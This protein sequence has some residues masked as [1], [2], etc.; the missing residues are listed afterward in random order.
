M[1]STVT[2]LRFPGRYVSVL[3]NASHAEAV[4]ACKSDAAALFG[5]IRVNPAN[6]ATADRIPTGNTPLLF[7]GS[8]GWLPS[9]SGL[10]IPDPGFVQGKPVGLWWRAEVDARGFMKPLVHVFLDGGIRAMHPRMGGP[11][12]FDLEGQKRQAGNTGVGTYAVENGQFVQRYDG[13]ENK[14]AHSSGSDS[15]GTYFKSGAE[16]FR[17]LTLAT[18]Q[19]ID[20]HWRGG[21]SE[22]NF[23]AD[24]TYFY[25]SSLAKKGSSG[26]YRLDG[27][28]IQMIPNDGRGAIDMIG[29]GGETLVMGS[30][31]LFRVK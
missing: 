26:R 27:Y 29:M 2:V 1:I 16:V 5:S 25:G 8:V 21:Q 19:S 13:F 9:G 7:T 23:R 6:G 30:T 10:P 15:S 18:I 3:F 11:Q 31:L 22:I 24:G 28:L 12:L 14:G 4:E 20:G 17:P